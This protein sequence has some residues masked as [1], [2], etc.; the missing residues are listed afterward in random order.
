[1]SSAYFFINSIPHQGTILANFVPI[2]KQNDPNLDQC[3][4]NCLNELKP[5]LAIGIPEMRI[6]P[7]DPLT[8]EQTMFK[9]PSMSATFID[10]KLYK[11]QNFDLQALHF[12]VANNVLSMNVSY[13][14]LLHTGNYTL[15]GR[16]LAF[17]LNGRGR[18]EAN[19]SK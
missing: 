14:E 9:T 10:N 13:E 16:L 1:M 17:Q 6:Y 15:S 2:C 7:F 8:I 5:K 12:D 3:I 11:G 18:L 4:I 19:Y